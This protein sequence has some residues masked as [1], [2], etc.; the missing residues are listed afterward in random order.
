MG[1]GQDVGGMIGNK[2]KLDEWIQLHS[3]H[4]RNESDRANR[5][6]S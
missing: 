1:Y 4:Y 6:F 2:K 3:V 5:E